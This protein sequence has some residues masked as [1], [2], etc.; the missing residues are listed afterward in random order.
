MQVLEIRYLKILLMMACLLGPATL[1]AAPAGAVPDLPRVKK[2][3]RILLKSGE[4]DKVIAELTRL[5]SSSDVATKRFA[6]EFLGVARQ[7]KGQLEFARLEYQRFLDEFPNAPEAARVRMRLQALVQSTLPQHNKSV[8]MHASRSRR[9]ATRDLHGSVSLS[10]RGSRN[11]DNSGR[12]T[13]SLSMPGVDVDLVGRKIGDNSSAGFRISAGRY[14]DL[15]P[16]GRN[17]TSRVSDLYVTYN[18]DDWLAVRVGRQRA[19]TR[20]VFG[21]F[22]GVNLALKTSHGPE[23]TVF[24]GL[25][26]DLSRQ[27]LFSD[28]RRFVGA[29]IDTGRIWSSVKFGVY[30]I[31]QTISGVVDRRAVGTELRYAGEHLYADAFAD[32]DVH[33]RKL[34]AVWLNMNKL[35]ADGGNINFSYSYQKSPYLSTRNALIGQTVDSITELQNLLSANDQLQVLALDRSLD[36]QTATLGFSRP[37][38]EDL[39]VSASVTWYNVGAGA[40]SG[41]LPATPRFSEIYG[42]TRLNVSDFLVKNQTLNVGVTY[43]TQQMSHVWSLFSS[44]I[45][46]LGN[47][48]NLSPRMRVDMRHN[49]DGSTQTNY[50]P[51]LR[52]QFRTGPNVFFAQGGYLLYYRRFPVLDQQKYGISFVYLGYRYQF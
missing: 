17:S 39:G 20:A 11:T 31:N 41:G 10:Y 3:V 37:L 9:D 24:T 7:R 4:F 42:E 29:G 22:D 18:F 40:A 46:R 38:T 16:G 8:S 2:Q 1:S 48:W 34:N 12:S 23:F 5:R 36:S 45:Y 43:S 52:M 49:L 6:Q 47:R 51:S 50:A 14:Q 32:Y 15:L 19:S 26:V 25:P 30:G 28:T 33:F 27:P 21:R 44:T 35:G 13:T